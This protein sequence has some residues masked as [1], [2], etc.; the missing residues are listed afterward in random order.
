MR[1]FRDAKAIAQTLRDE[2]EAK[3][4]SLTHSDSLELAAKILGFHDW[5]TLAARIQSERKP[6][7]A[8]PGRTSR[9]EIILDDSI[10]DRYA[11]FYQLHDNIVFTITRDGNQL[12]TRFT[13]QQR[14]VPFFPE[15]DTEFF[16]KV[17]D[18]QISFITDGQ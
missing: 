15:S 12:L 16:A 8:K 13:G 11:G 7:D 17:I 6:P 1:D 18:D 3:G 5:N 10:L 4:V 2:L 14:P 9:Q